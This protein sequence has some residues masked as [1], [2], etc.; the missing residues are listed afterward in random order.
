MIPPSRHALHEPQP[1]Q[2]LSQQEPQSPYGP[3]SWQHIPWPSPQQPELAARIVEITVAIKA[4]FMI[5][6][7]LVESSFTAAS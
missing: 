3:E 7:S 1:P 6:E 2:S 4:F 5:A